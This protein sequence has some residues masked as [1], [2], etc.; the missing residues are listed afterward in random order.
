M[1]TLQYDLDEHEANYSS[2]KQDFCV[3]NLL[4]FGPDGRITFAALNYFGNSHDSGIAEDSGFYDRVLSLRAPFA[5]AADAAFPRG[6][7]FRGKLVRAAK[8][9]EGRTFY[10]GGALYETTL[11]KLRQGAE[12]GMRGFQAA[13]PRLSCP[14]PAD[15]HERNRVLQI[16]V[17]M[18]QLRTVYV[19]RIQLQTVFGGVEDWTATVGGRTVQF[20]RYKKSR[21]EAEGAQ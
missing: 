19:G 15:K 4:C 9:G 3:S 6:G 10:T 21:Q 8:A 12:W 17:G 11:V 16:A 1:W 14:L 20:C 2:W 18:Y 7:P 13:C 5:V